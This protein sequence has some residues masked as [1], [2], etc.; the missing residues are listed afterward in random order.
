MIIVFGLLA[1]AVV[2]TLHWYLWRR[3]VRDTTTGWGLPRRLG[4]A[5]LC[6]APNLSAPSGARG[7]ARPAPTTRHCPHPPNHP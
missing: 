4:T 7:T 3:L 1:L 5:P 6:S 2:T